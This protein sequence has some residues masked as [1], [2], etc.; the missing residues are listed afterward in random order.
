MLLVL[1][2]VAVSWGEGREC[3]QELLGATLTPCG[4]NHSRAAIFH[5]KE[6]CDG[7]N[8]PPPIWDLNCDVHCHAGSYLDVDEVTFR[9]A[10]SKC[11]KN[12]YNI[13][14]GE[15][16]SGSEGGWLKKRS[17]FS[18]YCWTAEWFEWVEGQ[19]CTP[20]TPGPTGAEIV[21][22][23]VSEPK[24]WVASDLV[25]YANLVR[26]GQLKVRYSKI[27][28][29][30]NGFHNG[31]LT[32]FVNGKPTHYDDSLQ[33]NHWQ[34]F[35]ME[36]SPGPT[37]VVVSFEKFYTQGQEDVSAKVTLLEVRGTSFSAHYCIPCIDGL[38]S[39]GS[40]HCEPCPVNTFL[41]I[42][43]TDQVCVPC[44]SD[45]YSPQ[46][47]TSES[48]CTQ[49]KPCTAEDYSQVASPCKDGRQ[50]LSFKWHEPVI[51]DPNSGV[52]L[53]TV[54][55]DQECAL[56]SPG[57][58]HAETAPGSGETVC[59]P[60]PEGTA[61][62]ES[63]VAFECIKCLPG[64]YTPKVWNVTAWP[65]IPDYFWNVCSPRDG[66]ECDTQYGWS[67]RGSYVWTGV[68]TDK[69]CDIIL[70]RS[71]NITEPNAFVKYQV[72][73]NVTGSASRLLFEI[74]GAAYNIFSANVQNMTVQ[75]VHL[76][77][78]IRVLKWIYRRETNSTH[79]H[80]WAALNW[81]SVIGLGEGGSPTCAIC[82][83]GHFSE[84]SS[85]DCKAC[86]AGFSHNRN[87]QG[88]EMCGP[89]LYSDVPGNLRGC[90]YCPKNTQPSDDHTRCIGIP[91]IS[92][93]NK[94]FAV[95]KLT[96]IEGSRPGYKTGICTENDRLKLFCSGNFYGPIPDK[97][98]NDFYLSVLNP[99]ELSLHKF[100]KFDSSPV[101][102]AWGV[103]NKTNL[104]FVQEQDLN[105]PDD[106]CV[107]DF[108][109]MVVNLGSKVMSVYGIAD[110]FVVRYA[111]GSLCSR[112][113]LERFSSE[114]AFICDKQ[115]G[116]GWPIY[117]RADRCTA[118]FTWRSKHAC[119]VCDLDTMPVTKS[120]CSDGHRTITAH[121][122]DTCIYP[123][124]KASLVWEEDCS[125][126]SDLM[127]SWWGLIGIIALCS[128]T[129]LAVVLFVCFCKVKKKYELLREESEPRG[130]ELT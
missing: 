89:G 29:M 73:V 3:S 64:T 9:S 12:T 91:F 47:S 126:A 102:Y 40:D 27:S 124:P 45:K 67:S 43:A 100:S 117:A 59:T 20:W 19:L 110:G 7:E 44:S 34:T 99:G 82:P 38:S 93:G 84:G 95:T 63:K 54:V 113:T 48:D 15:V 130:V 72:S 98:Y 1:L 128:L 22:G 52:A 51:C 23:D 39:I 85:E 127:T 96:G 2:A 18:T 74:D 25:Y 14:G 115:E 69:M 81:I 87:R 28:R 79:P 26:K 103:L 108:S 90:G 66:E 106:A 92:W 68:H 36:L 121:E 55:S 62:T 116:D 119:E 6:Q 53:P 46:G 49:R 24:T 120:P 37:E 125:T 88:C 50:M 86:P 5:W 8:P 94:T 31:A 32:I 56:C 33:R 76:D 17:R 58:Y 109:K 75:Q 21:S 118:F 70:S 129:V 41:S 13:G 11:P 80:D 16:I 122:S 78:G 61:L 111:N 71:V 123:G 112:S 105:I 97:S 65:S 114:I 104:P 77:K 35:T 30:L 101:A 42:S 60:C 10:C 4:Y 57:E 83:V 107:A